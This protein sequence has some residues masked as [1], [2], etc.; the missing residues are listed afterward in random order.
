MEPEPATQ[1]AAQREQRRELLERISFSV[2]HG[3]STHPLS[4][5][6]D[7]TVGDLRQ[8]VADLCGVAPDQQTLV[9][10]GTLLDTDSVTLLDAG[11]TEGAK[12]MLVG[13]EHG[14]RDRIPQA[15]L[16]AACKEAGNAA[17]KAGKLDEAIANYTEAIDLCP[18]NHIFLSN[19][20]AA[21][22]KRAVEGVS[23][24]TTSQQDFSAAAADAQRCID[25][26]PQFVKGYGRMAAALEGL[27]EFDRALVRAPLVT[28]AAGLVLRYLLCRADAA[29]A[30]C[31][32]L[33]EEDA[34]TDA[35]AD[36]FSAEPESPR[37]PSPPPPPS[38]AA[39]AAASSALRARQH[40]GLCTLSLGL[41]VGWSFEEIATHCVCAARIDDLWTGARLA[42]TWA[43]ALSAA[44]AAPPLTALLGAY[45]RRL[46]AGLEQDGGPPRRRRSPGR[47]RTR[48][49]SAETTKRPRKYELRF[50]VRFKDVTP[51]GIIPLHR[52]RY[53][54]CALPQGLRS[55]RT[56]VRC[57]P[58][59]PF[60]AR[61]R[62]VGASEGA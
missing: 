56:A 52:R 18:S 15:D 6:A 39:R 12:L 44:A 41:V 51:L 33:A 1:A 62:R 14:V 17:L 47:P 7:C 35:T 26:A 32:A 59:P 37:A 20:S 36:A 45:R 8:P 55:R 31:A 61:R 2:R 19:R 30:R 23:N 53:F 38:R 29:A 5:P 9:L 40:L 60:A 10:Q 57:A 42:L 13:S 46:A 49:R 28:A 21:Y 50:T 43:Y 22:A 11:V 4:L 34:A 3:K 24:A 25:L 16:A 27:G 48:S 54:L 58:G